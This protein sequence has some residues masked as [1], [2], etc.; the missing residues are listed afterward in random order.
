MR[1]L[2]RLIT[3]L[4]ALAFASLIVLYPRAI[5]DD[6]HEVNHGSLVILLIG[7]SFAWVCGLGFQPTH[8]WLRLF[9]HPFTAWGLMLLGAWL[10]FM[11]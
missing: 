11:D 1:S 3:F 2:V 9:F 4:A 10:T 5:A 8:R 7:M 6:M